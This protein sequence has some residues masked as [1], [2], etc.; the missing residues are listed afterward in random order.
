[1]FGSTSRFTRSFIFN[2]KITPE[3]RN[4]VKQRNF[5]NNY[6]KQTIWII[7]ILLTT[8]SCSYKNVPLGLRSTINEIDRNLNDTIKYDFR[9]APENVARAK[10][11][12]GL[13]LGIRSEKGLWSGSLLRTY[14]R[15]NG[16]KH[17]DDMSAIILTTYH[18]KLNK[19]P[20]KFREQKK[21]FK[22]YWKIAKIGR[23]TLYQWRS[24]NR[25][26]KINDSLNKIYYP[27]F[28]NT[29]LVMGSIGAWKFYENGNGSG[30]DVKMI[31]KII[32]RHETALK[33]KIVELGNTEEGFQLT[34]KVG[35]TIESNLYSVFLIPPEKN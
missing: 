13:G 18:R 22:E 17:P 28:S 24:A 10:H 3:V 29:K 16:I 33:L 5:S 9:I 19:Q 27:N 20:I 23:D 8:I 21:Y 12:F 26:E 35:D 15:L 1:M 6:M 4:C 2:R 14:F 25:P 32:E 34:E 11:H 31:A 30:I 7:L